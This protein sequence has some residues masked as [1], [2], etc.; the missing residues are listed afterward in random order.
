MTTPSLGFPLLRIPIRLR[1]RDDL[2][3]IAECNI[4]PALAI[5]TVETLR[6]SVYRSW[7]SP[8]SMCRPRR[9]LGKTSTSLLGDTQYSP[10]R[11]VS[12]TSRT[13]GSSS[14]ASIRAFSV[15]LSPHDFWRPIRVAPQL[16]DGLSGRHVQPRLQRTDCQPKY[17]V[18]RT[19]S[20]VVASTPLWAVCLAP[21]CHHPFGDNLRIAQW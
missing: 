6:V 13:S 2:R 16:V 21:I 8:L 1:L 7:P 18:L 20:S 3:L 17:A 10:I 14:T 15:M 5:P 12:N 19:R 4:R 11:K 9:C